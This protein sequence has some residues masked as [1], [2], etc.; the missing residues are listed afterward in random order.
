MSYGRW[1]AFGLVGVIAMIVGVYIGLRHPLWLYWGLAVVMG[2]IPFGYLPGVHVP[3]YL[4]FAAG[5]LLAA[6]IH[7]T[8]RASL[9]RVEILV[10]L[11]ILA[12]GLA[13]VATGVSLYSIMSFARWSI[14][15]MLVIGL[16]RLSRENLARFGRVFVCSATVNAVAGIAMA[17]VDQQQRLLK[18]L[19][20]FGYGVGAELRQNTALYVYSDEGSGTVGRTIR[21]GGTWVLPNSAGFCLTIAL[22][23][24]L[25]L[26]RGWIRAYMSAILLVALLLTLSRATLFSLAAGLLLVFLF[27]SMR[28]RDRQIAIGVVGLVAVGAFLTPMV[29][30][31]LLASFQSEDKG[32]SDRVKALE[33]FPHQLSGHWIF[34]LGWNRPE[35]RSGQA[36]Q[37]LNYV[38]NAPLLTVYRGGVITG[39]IFVA[40]LVVGCVMG[41]RAI[42]P[43]SICR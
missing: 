25:V 36:A 42:S 30:E 14:A 15:S 27:H 7:P 33:N 19:K 23:M 3:L 2:V 20:V 26:F 13:M 34:G 16:L 11:L 37:Q 24:C 35:F 17:T 40:I 38:S 12:A 5:A 41:Y 43:S 31:R 6:L 8:A 29:R 21:L 22:V 28:A 4:L 18:L 32:R 39:L 10:L 1:A 9:S